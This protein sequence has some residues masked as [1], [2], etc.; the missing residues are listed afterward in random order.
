MKSWG[1]DP[2]GA[3]VGFGTLSYKEKV[4]GKSVTKSR[5]VELR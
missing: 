1:G 4:D 2:Q 5:P 3:P